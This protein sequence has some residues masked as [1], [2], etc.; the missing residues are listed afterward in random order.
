MKLFF[1]FFFLLAFVQN[2]FA[3][4]TQKLCEKDNAFDIEAHISKQ[5]FH[6]CEEIYKTDKE[7][8]KKAI[9]SYKKNKPLDFNNISIIDQYKNDFHKFKVF[10]SHFTHIGYFIEDNDIDG[11]QMAIDAITWVW[12]DRQRKNYLNHRNS[13]G[14]TIAM[15]PVL[16][17]RKNNDR[18]DFIKTMCNAGVDFNQLSTPEQPGMPQPSPLSEGWSPL[19]VAVHN[20]S[21][22]VATEMLVCGADPNYVHPQGQESIA[23]LV[24]F[25][26]YW[27][28]YQTFLSYNP[29]L[30][31]VNA[32]GE[33]L[34]RAAYRGIG[35][36]GSLRQ[37]Q[38]I[39]DDLK[40]RGI[41][42]SLIGKKGEVFTAD[43]V[44]YENEFRNFSRQEIRSKGFDKDAV[45][46]SIEVKASTIE[47]AKSEAIK[48]ALDLCQRNGFSCAF[49]KIVK[50]DGDSADDSYS[51][52]RR[53]LP[54]DG[55]VLFIKR[56]RVETMVLGTQK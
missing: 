37:H 10:T 49:E 26:G 40:A 21:L 42:K 15:Y 23:H 3:F 34:L 41:T 11:F 4:D 1:S 22:K 52:L 46:N 44:V 56:V 50:I 38:K 36:M 9:L 33:T 8:Y 27:D 39:I 55:R 20:G 7:K 25:K 6:F 32:N 29:D 13:L 54:N 30:K 47:R 5:T 12:S 43:A 19:M 28:F 35:N 16:Y 53:T 51:K 2:L 17:N 48:N 18:A 14:L 45:F 24:A 31:K